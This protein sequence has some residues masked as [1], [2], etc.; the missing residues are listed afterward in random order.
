L[1]RER[2]WQVRAKEVVIATGAIERPL[3]F[4]DNDRPGVMLADAARIYVTRYGVRPGKRAVV[5]TAC[6]TAYAAASALQDAGVDVR[7]IADLRRDPAGPAVDAVRRRGIRVAGAMTVVGTRG[8]L[9]V[10]AVHLGSV[11]TD[12]DVVPGEEIACDLMLMSGGWTPSV[13]LYSQSRG[14]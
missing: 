2:L 8:R 11:G 5:F 12:G 1:P 7:L 13:H 9:R 10:S 4:P 3:V 14:K 6:D